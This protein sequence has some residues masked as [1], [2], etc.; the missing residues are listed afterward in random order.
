MA[1]FT[2]GGEEQE[3][4]DSDQAVIDSDEEEEANGQDQVVEDGD[5]ESAG[6]CSCLVGDSDKVWT[7]WV[8]Q[9][10]SASA[11]MH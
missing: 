3:D 8:A 9:I 6:W 10:S 2:S 7:R 11:N 5:G 1:C 4:D